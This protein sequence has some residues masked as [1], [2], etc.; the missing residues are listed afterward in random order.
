MIYV[1]QTLTPLL[2]TDNEIPDTHKQIANGQI[3]SFPIY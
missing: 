2:S 3:A 1:F